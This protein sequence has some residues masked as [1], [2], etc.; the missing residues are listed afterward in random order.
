M[1]RAGFTVNAVAVVV[2]A[3][4]VIGFAL[5]SHRAAAW[6]V[7]MPMVFVALGVATAASGWVTLDVE[8]E[9]LALVGEVTLAVILFG[10]AVRIDT[11]V[12]R[13][14]L[15]M[16]A[17]L[18]G[19]GLPLAIVLGTLIVAG[20]LPGI[21]LAEAALV[22]VILAPTDP[23]LG[24]AVV[25][26][27]AVPQRV[28]QGLNVESGLNDG[29]VLPAVLVLIAVVAGEDTAAGSWLGLLG[30][31]L[32]LGALIGI[33]VGFLG[34]WLIRRGAA[35]GRVEG[36]YAQL[37]TLSVAVLAL[38]GADL[39]GANGFIA[40]FSAGLAF[41]TM[42]DREAAHLDEYTEDT[43]RLLAVVAFFVFGN[44]FV[45]PAVSALSW[46][47]ALCGVLLLTV[48]RLLPVAL[49]LI[50]F[51]AAAPTVLFVGWFGPRG[52]ASILFGLLLVQ[53]EVPAAQEFFAVIATTVV[54]SV[55]LHGTTA[56]WGARRYG[57][58]FQAHKE[59]HNAMAEAVPVTAQRVRWQRNARHAG[60]G[61]PS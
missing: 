49:S 18:L 29:L 12:L 2:V 1:S 51:R 56:A 59:R 19:I 42:S 47:V 33:G 39:L 52:L 26:N 25:T 35:A 38:A 48:G 28:R 43:G 31:Q 41:G 11:R 44:V 45:L 14:E 23:A 13:R 50:G 54:A 24:Q 37:G 36:I 58:W 5:I 57:N 21:G 61:R 9:G 27:D 60:T 3:A 34:G 32:G 6:P 4:A 17:R 10:D 40:A 16:P 30:R 7:T 55:F 20:L 8:A 46:Q 53:R 15:G 22:A